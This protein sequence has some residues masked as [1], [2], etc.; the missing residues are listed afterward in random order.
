MVAAPIPAHSSGTARYRGRADRKRLPRRTQSLPVS[1]CGLSR[2]P[3]PGSGQQRIAAR[4]KGKADDGDVICGSFTSHPAAV[5]FS[6]G[7]LGKRHRCASWWS[8]T[9]PEFGRSWLEHSR[10]KDSGLT[11]SQTATS[12][13][14][15]AL[16]GDYELV[17]LDLLL[18]GRDGL[19]VLSELH[20][21]R[22][23]LPVLILSARSDLAT[24]LRG[25]RAR[26]R[27][28]RRQAVLAGRAVRPRAGADA[29][30][31]YRRR[32]HDAAGRPAWRST[33]PG[34][35]PGWGSRWP[36]CPTASFGCCIS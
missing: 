5:M 24:K 29:R 2:L 12:G 20:R 27:R 6:P 4:P 22:P 16:T 28:L 33:S 8:R 18:P 21:K 31:P 34:G 11:W 23:G 25:F 17:I 3:S 15:L 26:R 13:L 1:M 9:K 30:R 36:A 14:G 7:R 10:S 35:R 19:D 32:R